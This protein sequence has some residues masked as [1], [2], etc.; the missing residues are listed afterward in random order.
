MSFGDQ[1]RESAV[2]NRAT[3]LLAICL[4]A[5]SC[6]SP[7]SLEAGLTIPPSAGTS[8]PLSACLVTGAWDSDNHQVTPPAVI[9]CV[10]P[11]YPRRMRAAGEQGDIVIRVA[12]DSAGVPDTT[13]L[14]VV[15]ATTASLVAPTRAAIP[16]LRFS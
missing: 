8:A 9:R 12:I 14:H 1:M 10:V 2:H 11:E 4:L 16:Y 13:T 3:S 6:A 7:Q 15:R 5:A